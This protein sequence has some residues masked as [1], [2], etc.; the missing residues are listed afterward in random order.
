MSY[1]P[2]DVEFL[3]THATDIT[4][5]AATLELT[6]KSQLRDAATLKDRFGEHG[7]AVSELLHARRS[8]KLPEDWLM[9]LSLIHI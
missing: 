4:A 5:A 2:D 8:G 7:R 9:D 6:K 3:A 1:T